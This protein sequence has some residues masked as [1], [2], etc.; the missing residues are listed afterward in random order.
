[1]SEEAL[2]ALDDLILASKTIAGNVNWS[3]E[4]RPSRAFSFS[5]LLRFDKDASGN[6]K[7][8]GAA[9]SAGQTGWINLTLV[10]ADIPVERTRYLPPRAHTNKSPEWAPPD[11]HYLHFAPL[12]SRRYAWGNNRVLPHEKRQEIAS[13]PEENLV[14]ASDAI[15]YALRTMNIQGEVPAPKFQPT[16]ELL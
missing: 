2:C 15:R 9:A 10:I 1:M 14:D 5:A 13:Y 7:L 16:L 11:L 4:D 8:H 12:I 3:Q 6:L